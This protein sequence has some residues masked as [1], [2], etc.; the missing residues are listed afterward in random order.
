MSNGR[1]A[2]RDTDAPRGTFRRGKAWAIR[3]TCGAAHVHEETIGPVKRDA[4][5]AHSARRAQVRGT[6]GWCPRAEQAAV[7]DRA[8]QVAA[9]RITFRQYADDYVTWAAVNKRSARKERYLVD[10]LLVELGERMIATI[11]TADVERLRDRLLAEGRMGSTVNRY[12]DLVSAMFKRAVRLGL[13]PTNPVK[14]IPKFRETGQ[15]IVWLGTEEEATLRDAL[16]ERLRPAFTLA[17]HAGL[18][19]SEQASLRWRDIDVLTNTITVEVSKNGR[20]RAVPTNSPVRAALVDLASRRVCPDDPDE[21]LFPLSHRQTAILFG[22]AVERAQAALRDDGKDAPHVRLAARD[23]R[24]G[25]QDGA[26]TRRLAHV[27]DGGEVRPLEFDTL[28][29]RG[30]AH[31]RVRQRRCGTWT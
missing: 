26:G 30:R 19:W 24:C 29:C 6:P 12:R 25:S 3:F 13:V 18:R 20:R 15:R 8:A 10:R 5:A 9:Q 2:K 23:G 11:T 17:V 14:G 28:A 22:K 16:P 1:N 7:R 31:R 4:M 21:R 27:V